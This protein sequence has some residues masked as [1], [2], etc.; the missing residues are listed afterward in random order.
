MSSP[1]KVHRTPKQKFEAVQLY[2]L[3]GGNVPKT[4]G[5]LKIP[6]QT[7]WQWKKT[8]W[9]HEY[10]AQIRRE[11]NLE[12][13]ARLKRSMAKAMEIVEDRLDKG[14]WIYDQKSGEMR[15]KPV[16]LKDAQ[17]TVVEFIDKRTQLVENQQLTIA[18][19][20]IEDKLAKLALAFSNLSKPQVNVTDVVFVENGDSSTELS[21]DFSDF[22]DLGPD[23]LPEQ[24]V[25]IGNAT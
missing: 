15:R 9:W 23:D 8:D 18:A 25:E 2:L 5:A 21:E 3:L 13:S 19:E 20:Q 24:K 22:E 7:M 4:A 12:L 16:S 11:E 10:E 14:D 1:T 6:E 17:K